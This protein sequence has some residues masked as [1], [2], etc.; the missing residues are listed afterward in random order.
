MKKKVFLACLMALMLVFACACSKT[1]KG[2]GNPDEGSVT[3]SETSLNLFVGGTATLIAT[4]EPEGT[5]VEWS[6]DKPAV[7]SV[8]GGVVTALS[9]GTATVTAT[10]GYAQAQ[11]TVSVTQNL[12]SLYTVTLS[13]SST[14]L[15]VGD[16]VSLSAT[17]KLGSAVV[18]GAQVTWSVPQGGAYVSVNSSGAV[19]ANDEGSAVVRATYTPESGSPVTADCEITVL[20]PEV[21]YDVRPDGVRQNARVVM[22]GEQF[23]A[24]PVV[25]ESGIQVPAQLSE[26]TFSSLN[27]DILEY[28]G[29]GVFRALKTGTAGIKAGYEGAEGS[30]QVRVWGVTA[31][32]FIPGHQDLA[33][34][35]LEDVEGGRIKLTS[36]SAPASPWQ[37]NSHCFSYLTGD[38]WDELLAIAEECGYIK[39]TMHVYNN[40]GCYCSNP[41]NKNYTMFSGGSAYYAISDESFMMS[42]LIADIKSWPGLYVGAIGPGSFEFT[43]SLVKYEVTLDGNDDEGTIELGE[44]FTLTPTVFDVNGEVSGLALSEFN[45]TILTPG[46][47][48]ALGGGKFEAVGLGN[49]TIRVEYKGAVCDYKIRVTDPDAPYMI[50]ADMFTYGDM[51]YGSSLTPA[52]DGKISFYSNATGQN[53]GY[54]IEANCFLQDDAWANLLAKADKKGYINLVMTVYLNENNVLNK[55]Y[56]AG[57]QSMVDGPVGTVTEYDAPLVFTKSI[58]TIKGWSALF[59]AG[60]GQGTCV[61]TLALV[62]YEVTLTDG[63]GDEGAIDLGE[64]FT[65]TPAVSDVNGAVS[66]TLSEFSF[67]I[68]TPGIL[69]ALGGGKFEAVGLGYATI[70]VE[71]KGAVCDYE[72]Q[73]TDPDAP[74]YIT[75]D[76]FA[77]GGG[78]EW[79]SA[80][81]GINDNKISF[82]NWSGAQNWY[83]LP[84]ADLLLLAAEKGYTQFVMTI[85]LN[86]DI[87][88][89]GAWYDI[90]MIDLPLGWTAVYPNCTVTAS[91]A[92]RIFTL[93]ISEMQ[94][95]GSL[96]IATFG[97]PGSLVFTLAMVK[98]EV[99]LTD[100]D[101]DSGVIELGENFTLT[102]TVFDVNG[103][104]SGLALSEFN[105]TILTPGI[106]EDLG[107]GEFKAVGAG[108][109]TIRVEYKGA[110]CDYKIQVKDPNGPLYITAD[111]FGEPGGVEWGGSSLADVNDNKIQLDI[112]IGGEAPNHRY[113]NLDLADLLLLAAEKGYTQFVMTI[114]LNEDVFARGGWV[115]VPGGYTNVVVDMIP[116]SIG[117]ENVYPGCTVTASDPPV[118]LTLNISE[119]QTKEYLQIAAK[120]GPGSL[121][122]TLAMVK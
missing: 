58:S 109:V 61:F 107:G 42:R 54:Y 110:V 14:Q 72:I 121:I 17:V 108:Y 106:L 28:L 38:A 77:Y 66:T 56:W 97:G 23:T 81:E 6:V 90:D 118:I 2:D 13:I 95:K 85:Y 15:Y 94:G 75:A 84:L 12:N 73:V 5:A 35:G 76:M 46:I 96:Q 40:T 33:P 37:W 71:Y 69:K 39:L 86:E 116:T 20:P 47:L 26:F 11:C 98:Y 93:N 44:N 30:A 62:K 59:L 70:R 24:E 32:D 89:R 4:V 29:N 88:S 114:Y 31:A 55:A 78:V 49:A 48:K 99:A 79:G 9:V 10:A 43:L 119:I 74:L 22:V 120:G 64:T 117:W 57:V 67:T 36:T 122:F 112:W 8:D 34:H 87:F 50:T 82:S 100:G 41:D 111:M 1:P 25:F 103:V 105:F 113:Y 115:S 45:F 65:L 51:Q 21:F 104:V 18:A 27:G 52:L 3:L 83:N 60:T 16:T 101:G 63:N 53:A 91:D 19:T 102:P 7:V 80:F 92:P 68:L